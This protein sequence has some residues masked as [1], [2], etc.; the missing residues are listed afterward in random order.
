MSLVQYVGG[1]LFLDHHRASARQF[2]KW[3][4]PSMVWEYFAPHIQ[5]PNHT[6]TQRLTTLITNLVTKEVE[7]AQLPP[8]AAPPSATRQQF[9]TQQQFTTQQLRDHAVRT[10]E[11]WQKARQDHSE[12]FQNEFDT[13]V[14]QFNRM[15]QHR[16]Y[17]VTQL[18]NA[19]AL[20]STILT[21]KPAH[22]HP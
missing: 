15:M 16:I 10:V 2:H 22:T 20:L 4:E 1:E 9:I 19:I 13:T 8:A 5:P 7:S 17:L 3:A 12:W 11:Q 6:L 21:S 14:Q 18:N